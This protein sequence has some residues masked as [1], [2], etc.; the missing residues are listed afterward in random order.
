MLVALLCRLLDAVS[1]D[2]ALEDAYYLLDHAL[3]NDRIDVQSYTKQLRAL[4]RKQFYARC[5]IM[6]IQAQQ[7]A[8]PQQQQQQQPAPQHMQAAQNFAMEQ[9]QQQ[10][11]NVAGL[12]PQQNPQSRVYG[13]GNAAAVAQ[14]S[15]SY[16]Q[17]PQPP[18][19]YASPPVMHVGPPV[20]QQQQ[21]QQQWG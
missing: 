14:P 12:L 10:Q 15:V 17:Y 1:L 2:H 8:N 3:Q 6:Q 20:V 9:Q 19:N 18:H 11:Q 16:P 21:L 13:G 7:A 4:S 5:L